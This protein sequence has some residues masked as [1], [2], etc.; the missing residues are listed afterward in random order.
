MAFSTCILYLINITVGGIS[1][2]YWQ[3]PICPVPGEVFKE[4][5]DFK[6]H[7]LLLVNF[8]MFHPLKIMED[9][10]AKQKCFID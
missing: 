4:V 6:Y 10:I 1:D 3:A 2:Q 7:L 8:A 9:Q 5:Q